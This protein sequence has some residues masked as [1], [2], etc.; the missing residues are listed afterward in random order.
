MI[1]RWFRNLARLCVKIAAF[2][3]SSRPWVSGLAVVL[4]LLVTSVDYERHLAFSDL[5]LEAYPVLELEGYRRLLVLAPHSDDETL[6]AGGLIQAAL[7]QGMDVHVVIVTAGDGYRRAAI[8][9]SQRLLPTARDFIAL[10]ELR[11]GESLLALSRLGLHR[12]QIDFLGYP[13]G[14]LASLWWEHWESNRPYRSP[15]TRQEHSPYPFNSGVPYSGEMLLKQLLGIIRRERPDLIV[16][17]H[18]NDENSDHYT[19]SAFLILAVDMEHLE[20][21]TYSPQLLSYLVHYGLYPQPLGFRPGAGL[22]PPRRL[23]QIGRWLQFPLST[24]ELATKREAIEGY[25]SQQRVLRPYLLSFVRRNEMFMKVDGAAEVGIVDS[26][27]TSSDPDAIVSLPSRPDP[28]TDR[29]VRKAS[30]GAD[31][32]GL[33]VFRVHDRLWIVVETRTRVSRAYSYHLLVRSFTPQSTRRW[34]A[35]WERTSQDN[36]LACGN[37]L[38]YSLDSDALGDPDWL[39]VTAE[40]RKGVIVLDRTAWYLIRLKDF[41]SEDIVPAH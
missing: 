13:D 2:P 9:E 25:V 31:I 4:L 6:G 33:R 14:G 27:I 38:W 18:P 16:M 34:S 32:T 30:G 8:A 29:L 36:A 19:L 40:T 11:Y 5:P 35:H 22:L 23:R 3:F 37:T 15:Y 26:E 41:I 20:D 10:G 12:E 17:P 39:A 7:R 28:T 24:T 1:R 21:P